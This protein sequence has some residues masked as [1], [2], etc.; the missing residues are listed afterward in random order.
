[1]SL[2]ENIDQFRYADIV[3]DISH[4]ALDRIFQYRIPDRFLTRARV[5][6]Q[7]R[8]PFG[9]GNRQITGFII[10]RREKPDYEPDRIK[11]ILSVEDESISVESQLIQVAGFLRERYGSTMIQALRTV[12]PVR[13]R[14]KPRT[15]VRIKLLADH[16]RVKD[17]LEAYERRHAGRRRALLTLLLEKG[18]ISKEEAM[19]V[20][21]LPAAELKKLAKQGIL[22][23]QERISWRNP[24]EAIPVI[25]KNIDLN[26]EQSLACRTFFE[27]YDQGKRETYLLY[28]VTGSGKT[29]VYLSMIRHVL[30][31]GK[32]AIVLIPEI[33]LTYQ[34]VRRF[35]EHFGNRIAVVNSRMSKGERY[36]ASERIRRREA[37]V[38]IGPRSALFAPVQDLGIIIIDEEHDS[39]FKSDTTPKYHAVDVAAFRARLAGA[40][41][42]LG[43]ATPLTETYEKAVRGEYR[44]LTLRQRPGGSRMPDTEIVDLREEFRRGNR[45]IFSDRLRELI[46]DR[47]DRREQIMLFVNRRGFAGFVSCRSCGHVLKCPHCDV[48]MTYH[49]NGTLV[50]HYCGFSRRFEQV[51]PECGSPHVAAFGIGTEKIEAA[52]RGEFPQAKV[53][54]MDA[55]T[56]RRKNAHDQILAAFSN[57]EADILL[58]TQMIVKGHDY[59][60]VTLVGVLSADLSMF[61]RDFR[62]GERTFQLLCQ[63]AGRAGRGDKK[64]MVVIQTYRPEHY[65]VCAAA[66]QSYETFYENETAYRKMMGYPPFGHILAILIQSTEEEEAR[67]G[68]ARIVRMLEKS[69]EKEEEPVMILNPGSAS[70]SRIKDVYRYLLYLKSDDRD[71]LTDLRQRLETVLQEHEMFSRI[72][73]QFD[74]DPMRSY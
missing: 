3:V 23:W 6:S 69:Q 63:A 64:G 68:Q 61:D 52:L 37:D 21:A 66:A 24:Y 39:A 32:Q 13:T 26:D 16:Q 34:T 40:S 54:R 56:T 51:C 20:S 57:R 4:E 58:G 2:P 44:L 8:I 1:M 15:E 31:Q 65:A 70:I 33:S 22:E 47:L 30:E 29:E 49:R 48:S 27:D 74:L 14:V 10:A 55:D 7:V 73:V 45:S 25:S 9:K 41:L 53:L 59:A 11:E 18:E 62:S 67:I 71:R 35:Y 50:C 43:S 19:E 5:G 60:N 46:S 36:D 28:G 42:V 12:M 72:Q 17:L 38:V